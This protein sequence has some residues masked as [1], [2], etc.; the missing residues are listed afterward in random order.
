MKKMI[1][2]VLLLAMMVSFCAWTTWRVERIC[3]G[4]AD[5]LG[6]AEESSDAGDF[7]DAEALVRRAYGLWT[8]HEGF[9]GMALRH[10]ESDDI[11]ILFPA[12]LESCR[13]E[14]AGELSYRSMELR[15]ALW[16]LSRME[17]PYY[18]NIL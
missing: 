3:R 9:L 18:F 8:G 2:P 6:Q 15:A 11:D 4:T 16:Q 10:T 7:E 17:Q 13:E 1:A 14:D 12:L 5:L